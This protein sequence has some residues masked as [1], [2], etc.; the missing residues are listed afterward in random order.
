M[1][2]CPSF[3]VEGTYRVPNFCTVAEFLDNN[4][5]TFY[6]LLFLLTTYT[7]CASC[8]HVHDDANENQY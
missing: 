8:W 5:L 6:S 1:V 7:I 4:F 2:E 3:V